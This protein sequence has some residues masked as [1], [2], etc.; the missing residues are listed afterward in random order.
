MR[1]RAALEYNYVGTV[2]GHFAADQARWTRATP[3]ALRLHLL[4]PLHLHLLPARPS[5][6]PEHPFL[7]GPHICCRDG[8][9]LHVPLH[10]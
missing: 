8:L 6:G 5:C 4:L 9:T 3:Y 10:A 2:H 7:R 1:R